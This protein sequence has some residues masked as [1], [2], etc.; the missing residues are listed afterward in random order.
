MESFCNDEQDLS[1][2]VMFLNCM[3]FFIFI[4]I[5]NNVVCLPFIF[6]TSCRFFLQWPPFTIL[7]TFVQMLS[8]RVGI[9]SEKNISRGLDCFLE[10]CAEHHKQISDRR[11][12]PG[13]WN[14]YFWQSQGPLKEGN[15]WYT[16]VNCIGWGY[17]SI[18]A[19]CRRGQMR[20]YLSDW[21]CL[22]YS[23]SCKK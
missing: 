21:V 16:K 8:M 6:V 23:L 1:L 2:A 15:N 3:H 18:C 4:H 14:V 13:D 19:G 7:A 17:T 10:T 12:K 11:W 9:F 5:V 20:R 22:N